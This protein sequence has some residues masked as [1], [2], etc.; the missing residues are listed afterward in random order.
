MSDRNREGAYPEF[1]DKLD[2]SDLCEAGDKGVGGNAV[3]A[4]GADGA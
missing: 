4:I 2:V 1:L 3:Y